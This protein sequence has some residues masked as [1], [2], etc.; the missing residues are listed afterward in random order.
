MTTSTS[1]VRRQYLTMAQA[2]RI[3]PNKPSP[4]TPWRWARQGVK[5]RSGEWVRLRCARVGGRVYTTAEWL[6]QFFDDLAEADAVG[7]RQ[8]PPQQ[9]HPRADAV[10]ADLHTPEADIDQ[11]LRDEGL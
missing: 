11:R 3:A 1:D 5:A 6:H 7:F 4:Q 9:A 10:A 2:A 8:P